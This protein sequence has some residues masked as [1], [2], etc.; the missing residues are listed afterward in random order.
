V[1][2]RLG[3]FQRFLAPVRDGRKVTT[4][5]KARL[6]RSLRPGDLLTLAFGARHD[7]AL[8]SACCTSLEAIGSD[9]SPEEMER[10]AERDGISVDELRGILASDEPMVVISFRL[11]PS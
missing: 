11:E 8:L 4:I 1:A 9:F 10:L 2:R 3:F 7:P 5:R 6:V